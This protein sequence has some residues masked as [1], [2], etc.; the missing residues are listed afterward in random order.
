MG[1]GKERETEREV[2]PCDFVAHY[3]LSGIFIA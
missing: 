1:N 3:T 2:E